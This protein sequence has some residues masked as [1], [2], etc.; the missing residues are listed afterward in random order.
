MPR[1]AL[2]CLVALLAACALAPAAQPDGWQML[3][4]PGFWDEGSDGRFQNHNG[5]AW[6]RCF[7]EVPASWKGEDLVLDLGT[8]DDSDEGFV[9]GTK[10]GATGS[11]PPDYK[12]NNGAH[13]RYTVPA[14]AVRPGDW[15][16]VAVRVYDGGGGGGIDAGR[17]ALARGSEAL[18]LVGN[19]QFRLGDDTAWAQWPDQ[20]DPETLAKAYLKAAKEHVGVPVRQTGYSKGGALP[21][22]DY[23]K[24]T[25]EGAD[26]VRAPDG[27]WVLWYR[28]PAADWSWALPV[29]NGSMGAMVYGGAD[30][31]RIQFNH[32]TLWTGQP[33]DY[34]NPGAAEYLPKVRELLFADK[35]REAQQLAAQHCMSKPLRQESYQPFGDLVLTFPEAH[36]TVTGYRRSL[37]LDEAS[38]RTEYTAGGVRYTREVLASY[39]D[40]IIAVRVTADKPGALSFD[41]SLLSPHAQHDVVRIAADTL[42]IRG[43]VTHT[44]KTRTPS[45]L[46]FEARLLARSDGGKVEVSDDAVH[47]T[48]ASAATLILTAATSYKNYTDISADPAARCATVLAA[49]GKKS[50]EAIRKDHV[51]DHQRLFRRVDLDVGTTDAARADTVARIGGFEKGNDPHLA[52]LLFQYGRYLLIACSRPGSQPANLQGIWNHHLNPP[53]ECKYTVNINTEMN[54][55]P[56]ELTNLSECHDPLFDML[57][58]CSVAG[59]KTTRTFYDCPGWVLHHNTEVWRG[60]APINASNHGI[61]PTGGAWLCQHLWL[62]YAFTG[63]TDFL[64]TR[65]YPVMKKA[66][67]FFVAFLVDDPVNGKGWLVSGPSNSPERG[68]L[69]M[70]PTMDHQIIRNLFGNCIEASRILGVDEAFR[71]KLTAMHKRIAP[72]QVGAEGQLKEWLYKEEPKTTHRHVSHLWGLHPGIEITRRGTPD[73]W[74]AA[75]KTLEFR[76]DGGTGWSMAWKINFWARFEDGDHAYR[77]LANLL[78]LAGTGKHRGGMYPNLFDAH[79]PFQIDGNFGATSG[80]AEM[81]LAS[82]TGEVHLLPALPSAWPTGS[83]KGLCARGGFRVDI[84][85]AEGAVTEAKLLSNVGGPCRLRTAVPASVTCNGRTVK[86]TQPEAGVIAFATEKDAT[87]LIQRAK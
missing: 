16:L 56:A 63:D 38:A 52:A 73:I 64:R 59:A 77:M 24:A 26:A 3:R 57:K 28:Q 71:T 50:H 10:V 75:M 37:D 55:W 67:E 46:R 27:R 8:I 81:L 17:P 87:Y 42:A 45:K 80:I 11:M 15:N 68:G 44:G 43:Q 31:E 47:V 49:L 58:D 23:G 6:Y 14:R 41:A 83:V 1:T 70:G 65:A 33:Q 69:V 22:I 76:G 60:T 18:S 39:P 20:A 82:H 35:Q 74:K 84:A 36:R 29:G 66:A 32:D 4:V 7:V 34:Q 13:R 40:H 54:Y 79:P 21:P 86:T 72:N 9:N 25:I 51:A 85:W 62:R 19:W 53:W 61:W 12:G 78:H 5:F 48:G 2:V 30:V